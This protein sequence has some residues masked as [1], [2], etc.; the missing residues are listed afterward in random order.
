MTKVFILSVGLLLFCVEGTMAQQ[1]KVEFEGR[2]WISE[3]D[4]KAKVVSNS[5]GTDFDFQSDL[6]LGDEDFTEGRIYWNASKN[7]KIRLAYTEIG[8][9]GSKNITESI[10]FDG[11]TYSIGAL[12]NT[13]LDLTYFKL[14]WIWQRLSFL[15]NTIKV[16]TLLE[17]KGLMADVS[18]AAPNELPSISES[19]DFIGG[20]PTFGV[21]V[22]LLPMEQL[23]VFFEISGLPAGDFGYFFDAEVGVK[24]IPFKNFSIIAGYRMIDIK[25]EDDPDFV[26]IEISGPFIGGTLRF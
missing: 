8:Y 14:G 4:A 17:A 9:S 22:N 19:A 1:N 3:L 13:E 16:G 7:S 6:G 25:A 12:V 18:L 10:E 15:D 11:K 23:D 21:A 2:Y 5:V 20:L 24:Y 26:E